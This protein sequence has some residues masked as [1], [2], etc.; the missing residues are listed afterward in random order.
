MYHVPQLLVFEWEF[1]N[2]LLDLQV[3]QNVVYNVIHRVCEYI[4]LHHD[5]KIQNFLTE[6]NVQY[7]LNRL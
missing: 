7:F 4:L 5:Y 1:L 3:M 2:N 6:I